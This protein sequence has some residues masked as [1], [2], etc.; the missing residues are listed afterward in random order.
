MAASANVMKDSHEI[1][2]IGVQRIGVGESHRVDRKQTI[3]QSVL[4]MVGRGLNE[5]L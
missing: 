4:S 2:A 3:N 1:G 5:S